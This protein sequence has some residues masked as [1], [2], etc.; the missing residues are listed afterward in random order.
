MLSIDWDDALVREICVCES[1]PDAWQLLLANRAR[2]PAEQRAAIW[3]R[4]R[5]ELFERKI[6]RLR[7]A[8]AA[9]EAN[10]AAQS[11]KRS[12]PGGQR[13]RLS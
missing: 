6:E 3:A 11:R 2:W 13:L 5:D 10:A 12:S 1:G 4:R 9:R 8:K 7:A